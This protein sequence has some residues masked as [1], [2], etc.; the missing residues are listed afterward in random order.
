[1]YL[2]VQFSFKTSDG[3]KSKKSIYVYFSRAVLVR[4]VDGKSSRDRRQS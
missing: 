3:H 1:M 4:V 2:L